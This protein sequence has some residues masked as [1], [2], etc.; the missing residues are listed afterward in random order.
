MLYN[1]K[2]HIVVSGGENEVNREW[3]EFI[4]TRCSDK[5]ST[6]SDVE[7]KSLVVFKKSKW[8]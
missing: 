2:E 8:K 7:K 6:E 4:L 5:I 3:E 1:G